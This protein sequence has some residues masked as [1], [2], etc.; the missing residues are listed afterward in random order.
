MNEEDYPQ[1]Y[2]ESFRPGGETCQKGMRTIICVNRR[3]SAVKLLECD[4][5]GR[6]VEDLIGKNL[7]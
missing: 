4:S 7:I 3:E 5:S 1:I 2:T 6:S